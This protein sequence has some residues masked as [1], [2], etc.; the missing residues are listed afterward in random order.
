M[1]DEWGEATDEPAREDA[2]H[3]L[4]VFERADNFAFA[5]GGEQIKNEFRRM[6]LREDRA[7]RAGFFLFTSDEKFSERPA[8]P[9]TKS[10]NASS[11]RCS[12]EIFRQR[13]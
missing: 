5:P 2:R 1:D 8:L 12:A 9:E 13:S 4:S 10:R 7:G 11:L 6:T 3:T